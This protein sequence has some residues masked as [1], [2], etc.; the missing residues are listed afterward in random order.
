MLPCARRREREGREGES[1]KGTRMT[2][3]IAVGVDGRFAMVCW[4]NEG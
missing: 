2:W 3:V 4:L 1:H